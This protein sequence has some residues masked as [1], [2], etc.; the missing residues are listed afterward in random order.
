MFKKKVKVYRSLSLDPATR[1]IAKQEAEEK[2]K[3]RPNMCAEEVDGLKKDVQKEV[4]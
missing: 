1:F 2:R 4:K 3:K